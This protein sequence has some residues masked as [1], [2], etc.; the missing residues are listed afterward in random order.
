MRTTFVG[1]VLL[2]TFGVAA[3]EQHDTPTLSDALA[4]NAQPDLSAP[5]FAANYASA[6]IECVVT[7]RS[8]LP[9]TRCGSATRISS[10]VRA[11]VI[12]QQ[13]TIVCVE[14][15]PPTYDARNGWWVV[16]FRLRN[17]SYQ[18]L[19]TLDGRTPSAWK[20]SLVMVDVPRATIGAG[21]IEVRS[22]TARISAH[23]SLPRSMPYL[24]YPGILPQGQ[25][26][27][28]RSF[29]LR[30]P[31]GIRQFTL[32]MVIVADLLPLVKI[33]EVM[34]GMRVGEMYAGAYV[35]LENVG[36]AAISTMTLLVVDSIPERKSAVVASMPISD[37]WQ[38]RE[39]RI[40]AAADLRSV[41]FTPVYGQFPSRHVF[42]N[43]YTNRIRVMSGGRYGK[44]LDDVWINPRTVALA[45]RAFERAYRDMGG[46]SSK[47]YDPAWTPATDLVP[48]RCAGALTCPVLR[49]TPG[50]SPL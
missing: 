24:T 12:A 10:D 48:T 34:P 45:G 22:P 37:D 1:L 41:L 14:P 13:C 9:S 42:D 28:F 46:T 5:R 20:T 32:R 26:S 36:S 50:K 44:V 29:G 11:T 4:A 30:I 25:P 18:P 47:V 49:G 31:S 27:E 6:H 40:V 2:L 7:I 15:L 43:T 21:T 39:R 33:T 3:C 8:D 19:G 16:Q 35:E 38:P 23:A 17:R